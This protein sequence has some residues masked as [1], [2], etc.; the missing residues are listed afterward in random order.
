MA[1]FWDLLAQTESE[2]RPTSP[3][4]R[5]SFLAAVA[6]A[7]EIWCVIWWPGGRFEELDLSRE[8]RS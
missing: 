7:G 4:W 3:A 5:V 1:K 6:L 8:M 2:R